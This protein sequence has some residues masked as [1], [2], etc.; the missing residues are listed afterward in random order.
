[1]DSSTG[2]SMPK[3]QYEDVQ[4]IPG[5]LGLF[6]DDDHRNLS[7]NDHSD[8]PT[9][10]PPSQ[11]LSESEFQISETNGSQGG[12]FSAESVSQPDVHRSLAEKHSCKERDYSHTLR[13]ALYEKDEIVNQLRSR[14]RQLRTTHQQETD[15]LQK[16]LQ[17]IQ[18]SAQLELEEQKLK[19]ATL[20]KIMHERET[21][22]R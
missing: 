14:L 13:R 2:T 11:S 22:S 15:K 9:S 8:A 19:V 16:Q 10:V 17:V 1:M 12:F 3:R 4:T 21:V 20:E 18:Q 6:G 7:L 5:D